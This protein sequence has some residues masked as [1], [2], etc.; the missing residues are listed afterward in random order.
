MFL[1]ALAVGILPFISLFVVRVVMDRDA[2][3][4]S[5]FF[6]HLIDLVQNSIEI[7]SDPNMIQLLNFIV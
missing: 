5:Q 1:D 2:N 6:E 4:F 3:V 7:D